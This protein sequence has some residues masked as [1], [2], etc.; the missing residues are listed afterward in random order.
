RTFTMR[1]TSSNIA[2]ADILSGSAGA[3]DARFTITKSLTWYAAAAVFKPTSSTADTTPPSVPAG[4]TA[5]N[6][7]G[8]VGLSW[9][10]STDN[11]GVS[12]YT[13]YRNGSVLGTVGGSVLS[14][15]DNTVSPSTTYTYTVDAFDAAGIHSGL[16]QAVTVTTL[17]QAD[18]TPPT[19]PAGLAATAGPA[20]EV[21]LSWTASTD[22]V[23]VAGYTV[24]RDGSSIGTVG[25]SATSFADK[26]VSSATTYA[27]TVDAYDAAGNHSGQSTAASITTPDW[28]PPTAPTG[29]SASA[30]SSSEI[31]QAWQAA[32]DNVGVA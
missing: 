27:Y 4:L 21:D 15:A 12:G 30:V 6:G 18:T 19:V 16:S 24:Y 5:T 29:L 7:S 17:G 3:Q 20:G 1:S 10:A 22:D 23:G 13:V 32:T 31:D 9:S 11:V 28:A 2:E 25:G 26:A 8:T 14:Y